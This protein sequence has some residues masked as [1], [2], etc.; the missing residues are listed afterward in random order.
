MTVVHELA[1]WYFR[2]RFGV[3]TDFC[4]TVCVVCLSFGFCSTFLY[5]YTLVQGFLTGGNGGNIGNSGGK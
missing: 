4:E 2:F 3:T 1:P 5:T